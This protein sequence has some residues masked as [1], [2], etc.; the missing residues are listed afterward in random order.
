MLN[1][2]IIYLTKSDRGRRD[3][4][5]GEKKIV[6]EMKSAQLELPL[7]IPVENHG[8]KTIPATQYLLDD[9]LLR[10]AIA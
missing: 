8:K 2:N 7:N 6:R 10:K 1:I 3:T 9:A 4:V 5:G